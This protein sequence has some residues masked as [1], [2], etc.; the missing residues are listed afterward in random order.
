MAASTDS[1]PAQAEAAAKI[2]QKDKSGLKVIGCGA[3]GVD[4][5]HEHL[6]EATVQWGLLRFQIGSGTFKRNKMLMIHFNGHNCPG[7]ARA[8]LNRNA[9]KVEQAFGHIAQKLDLSEIAEAGLDNIL[10]LTKKTLIGDALGSDF[11]LGSMKAEYE[12]MIADSRRK[13]IE[14]MIAGDSETAKRKTAKELGVEAEKALELVRK[15]MGAFNWA[16][17]KPDPADFKLYDAGSLGVN[18]MLDLL[19]ADDILCGLVRMG[20]GAGKFRRTKYISIWWAGPEVGAHAKG[21]ALGHGKEHTM[22]RLNPSLGPME[23]H[24]KDDLSLEAIIDKVRRAAVIDGEGVDGVG[25]AKGDA[26]EDPFSMDAYYAAL[27][28]EV[29]ANGAFFGEESSSAKERQFGVAHTI[30]EVSKTGGK[31]TW[32]LVE[33]DP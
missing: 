13:A 29:K 19:P 17:F 24:A 7:P 4:E 21:A 22:R 2:V 23:G 18:E 1:A 20:F 14:A 12:S 25:G 9:P 11:S 28:E 3:G 10:E 31:Y 6:S 26:A 8:K 30:R 33:A 32:V 5:M 16:L 15:P 27:E